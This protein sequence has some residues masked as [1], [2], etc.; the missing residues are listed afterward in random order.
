MR[1]GSARFPA[2]PPQGA[3]GFVS[4]AGCWVRSGRRPPV[5]AP[6]QSTQGAQ[7]T[8]GFVSRDGRALRSRTSGRAGRTGGVSWSGLSR[9]HGRR[10]PRSS[11]DG[12]RGV[13]RGSGGRAP[14]QG[15]DTGRDEG[16]TGRPGRSGVHDVWRTRLPGRSGAA[17]NPGGDRWQTPPDLASASRAPLSRARV[18]LFFLR[19]RLLFDLSPVRKV[20]RGSGKRRATRPSVR[21]RPRPAGGRL[22]LERSAPA[23]RRRLPPASRPRAATPSPPPTTATLTSPPAH[24]PS[25]SRSTGREWERQTPFSAPAGRGA[26]G[27][28]RPVDRGRGPEGRTMTGKCEGFP[29][30]TC[31]RANAVRHYLYE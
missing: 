10:G 25:P 7:G 31:N 14:V 3:V 11:S 12:P 21:S 18:A 1:Q 22:S 16:L 29:G 9:S 15:H 2:H 4:R 5:G 27:R 24:S 8:V 26:P 13:S 23:A 17:H 20:L 30:K 28:P 19:G 6:R